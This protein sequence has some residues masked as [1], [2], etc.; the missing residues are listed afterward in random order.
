MYSISSG[1]SVKDL[2]EKELVVL[3]E[4]SLI[5]DAVVAMKDRGISSVLVRSAYSFR[6][7]PN[8]TGIVTEKDIL[9]KVIGGNK[10]PYKTMLGDVM[11]SPVITIDAGVSVTEAMS[12]MRSLKIRRL[13]VLKKEKIKGVPLGLVTL[14]SIIGNVPIE[15][16]T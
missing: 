11:S 13:L 16:L 9:Y 4:D 1:P 5:S 10:G 2:V 15:D 7:N 3:P 14:M 12:L 6:G 8:I